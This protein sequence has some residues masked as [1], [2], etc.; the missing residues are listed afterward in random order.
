MHMEVASVR[1]KTCLAAAGFACLVGFPG[2]PAA[3]STSDRAVLE[4]FYDATGGPNWTD[5]TN[6]KTSAP[7]DEWFGVTAAGPGRVTRLDLRGNGLRGSIPAA[8]GDLA[9]LQALYLGGRWDAIGEYIPNALMGPI[10][11]ALG[12]LTNIEELDLYGNRLTGSIP[13]S[14]G[15]L[16]SLRLLNLDYNEL[17]GPIPSALGRLEKL[18]E[19]YLNGNA[20]T[21]RIPGDLGRLANLRSLELQSNAL[22][23]PIPT[24]LGSLV[25]LDRLALTGNRLTGPVPTWLGGLSRLRDLALRANELSGPIPAELGDLAN[26]QYLFLDVNELSGPIPPELGDLANLQWL[27]LGVNELSGAIPAELGNLANLEEL[28]L[29]YN[30]LSGAIPAELG[31]LANLEEL[32]L[33]YNELSGAIPAELGDLANLSVLRLGG[34]GLTGPIPPEL[35]SLVG[36]AELSLYENELTGRLPIELGALASLDRLDLSYNWGLS[37]P[38]PAGLEQSALEELDVFVTQTCAPAAWDEW[39]ATI[40]FWGP[41]CEAELDV[42][43]DVAVVY[44]PAAREWA[45]GGAGIEAVIDLMIA[46]TNEAYVAS[47]VG[48][49]LALVGRSEVPYTETFTDLDWDRLVEPE[50]GHMDAAHVLRDETGAD[51]VHLIVAAPY[52]ICG[53]AQLPGVFGITAIDCGGI[54]FAH[55]LGHNMGLRHDRFRVDLNEG[56]LSSHPAY[57]YVNHAVFG[58]GA[59]QSAR[60]VTIMSYREHC[61]LADVA[62]SELPRFSNPR[63]RYGGDPLGVPFGTG[64]GL[65]GASDAAAVLEAMGPAVA[66]WRERSTDAANRPPVA[67]GTLPDRRLES[68]GAVLEVDVSQAFVDPDGDA[69][70]YTAAS[71]EPWLVRAQATGGV[72]TL[73]GAGEGTATVRVAATDT[74]GLSVSHAFSATV[75]RPA[76]PDP[77]GS[78]ESDRAALEALYDATDGPN[79]TDGT[80]WKTS[81]PLGEW[82]G[83][84]TDADGRVTELSLPENGLAGPLPFE[85]AGLTN[86]ERLDL[87]VNELTGLVPPWLGSLSNLR[88]LDLSGLWDA[89]G[90]LSGPI[91]A[92]L[93]SLANLE[94]LDLNWNDLAGA[95]P[96]ALG[97]LANL[98][99]IAL[100]GNDLTGPVPVSFGNLPRLRY[101]DLSRNE[102]TGPIPSELGSLANLIDLYLYQNK[103]TDPI[104]RELGNLKNLQYLELGRNALT[105]RIPRELGSL[106]SL[107]TL[108][109]S[110]SDLSGPIPATLGNLANLE[111]LDLSYAWGLSGPLPAGLKQSALAELDIFVTRT[112]AP[113]AWDEWLATIEFWGP[114]CEAEPDVT[115]DI[116]V[117]YTPAARETAGGEAGIEAEIDLW[118]AETNQAYA[119][120]GVDLRLTLVGR[121]EVPYTETFGGQDVDRLRDPSDGYLDEAHALRDEV[122]ADLVHLIVSAADYF[123]CGIAAG[124][125]SVFGLTRLDCGGIVFAHELGHNLGLRHDRFRVQIVEDSVLSHPAY[126]Y[127]NQEMFGAG[128]PASSRWATIMAYEWF[129]CGLTDAR[130]SSVPRFSNPRQRYEGD[131]LGVAFGTGSGVTGA[132]DA[133]AVLNATGPA[134][135]AWRDRPPRVNRAPVA[136]GTLPDRRLNLGGTLTVDVS[137][138]FSDP[139]GDALTYAVSSSAPGVATVQALG[140]RVTLTGVGEGTAAIRVTAADPGG[141]SAS[142]TFAVTVARGN[143]PPEA[144]GILSA[145]RLPEP[146]ATLEVDVS[147]AFSDPDGDALTYAVSSSAP[148]VATVQALGRRVT[149]TGV[150]EGTAAI[151]VTAAD[152]GGLSASQTFAV[153][154]ARG[155]RPPEAV[156][157]LSAVRLPEPGATL[158]VDVSGA[159]SDPDGDA[160]TYAVSSSAPGVATVQAL[161]RRVTLT[162]VGEGT[163]AIRVTAAD[164]GGLSASQTFA[165]TVARGN[166]P[167]EAVGILSA[168][169]LPEPGATLEVDVSGAFSDPDG[170][171]LTYAAVSSAPGVATV[172]MS[173]V[174][175]TLT[176]VAPGKAVIEVT[177]S[178]PDGSSTSQTFDV[179]VTAPFTD[180]PIQPGVT[181]IKAVHFTELRTRIDIL[182]AETGLGRFRWTDSVLRPGVTPVKLAH[183]L[184]LRKALDEAFSAAG[185]PARRWTDA[186]PVRGTTPI[187]AVHLTE[188]R[189]AVVE[190]E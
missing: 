127:V 150:G 72:V 168:V 60:W 67:V 103:L 32:E 50:D 145:V 14:F 71:A 4:A 107:R 105:G 117:V 62:C 128:A 113:V 167:P 47:G 73:T 188:L 97:E 174:R 23:G 22:T 56:S 121:S 102:L 61:Y 64:S 66:A 154:V 57:G 143:R 158:E 18:E 109:L 178:D 51:L 166:R 171:A 35:G 136:V 155:N 7:L 40:E 88:R 120:S 152:P 10:P 135:A 69:L 26:L 101:L 104:P 160:L 181:P 46:E 8:I 9:F 175:V 156:G 108:D 83:V 163:A 20:L 39:L 2:T 112:C 161:G 142:Q 126:G 81:A 37:G 106:A 38:L 129:Q 172:Q 139:D 140:R 185:R 157:I 186:A 119:S 130:C 148:G 137:G 41:S 190:L 164:P 177:A 141:L 182:R 6:W 125:P 74:G 68:A 15:R 147:G 70:T 111:R 99:W 59:P 110:H 48:Q 98:E 87:A 80:N 77:Q 149:L 17:T 162:G 34:N 24:E 144:V 85:L 12:G 16:A 75:A 13:E 92:E 116:A 42:T 114:P 78:V 21:G 100:A 27:F 65:T 153:T 159:F 82:H 124:I 36:L 138:A 122:G 5:N 3:Q 90:L 94:R 173:G 189:A 86:L 131:P 151:R 54:T 55:E 19:L 184:E 170:D 146:G 118:I 84:T 43:I 53:V 133:V 28:E 76:D 176:A 165:V 89:P 91:P 58:A 30:E 52:P 132:A 45:G 95:V 11:A 44:T 179:R 25:N 33:D 31:N 123:V 49:R 63:Q 93:G 79:W 115:I 187:R 1:V 183:L 96:V 29:D 134:A 169:R 180:D